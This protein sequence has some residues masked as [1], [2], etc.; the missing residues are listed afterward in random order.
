M[1]GTLNRQCQLMWTSCKCLR[2]RC[3]FK[4]L[5]QTTGAWIFLI[6]CSLFYVRCSQMPRCNV[7]LDEFFMPKLW[8]AAGISNNVCL[9]NANLAAHHIDWQHFSIDRGHV[10]INTNEHGYINEILDLKV[11]RIWLE[12]DWSDF[13]RGGKRRCT[14]TRCWFRSLN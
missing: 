10:S 12:I 8:M 9:T 6:L 1:V 3:N 13:E 5:F 14:G 4:T 11:L 2:E 7:Q